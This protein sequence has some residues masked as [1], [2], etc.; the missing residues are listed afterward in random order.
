MKKFFVLMLLA[1][2][3][4]VGIAGFFVHQYLLRDYMVFVESFDNGLLTVDNRNTEGTDQKFRVKCKYGEYLTVSINPSRSER[5]YFDL[6]RLTVNGENVTDQVSM[7]QYRTKVTKKMTITASFKPGEETAA[8][9]SVAETLNLSAPSLDVTNNTPYLGSLGAYNVKDPSIIFDEASG[10]YY[11]FC[12]D[13]VVIHSKD[14]INWTAKTNYFKTVTTDDSTLAIDF[15]QFD[16]VKAWAAEHGYEKDKRYSSATNNRTVLAP[17]IVRVG[18][19]YYLYFSISKAEEANEAAIFCVKTKDLEAAVNNKKWTEVGIVFS[20]CGY[21]AGTAPAAG[22]KKASA[23]HYD[24][25]YA[26]HPSIFRSSDG[27]MYM[28]Y[29]G[30]W[31]RSEIHG[32]IYLLELD[33]KTGLLRE[34]SAINATGDTVSTVHGVTRY[35]TGALIAQPGSIPD[36]ARNEGSLIW[37]A[38]VVRKGDYYYLLTTYGV[39]ELNCSVRVARSDNPAG[40]Y[41]DSLGR[42]ISKFESQSFLGRDQY[43][44]GDILLAGYNFDRSNDGGVSYLNVGKASTASPSVIKTADGQWL[45]ASHSQIYFKVEGDLKTGY[46]NAKNLEESLDAKPAMEIRQLLWNDAGWPLAVPEAY[47]NETVKEKFTAKQMY[48]EWD[49]VVFDRMDGSVVGAPACS[50]SQMVSILS[51]V[52]ITKENIDKNTK[53]DKLYFAKRNSRSFEIRL[54]GELFIIYPVVAWDWELDKATLTFSGQG[55][56]GSTVWGK[57]S[58]SSMTGLYTDTLYYL[59]DQ[60]DPETLRPEYEAKLKKIQN[61]PTQSQINKLCTQLIQALQTAK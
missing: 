33:P 15:D 50:H 21:S 42:N 35:H 10:Y 25:S 18:K 36:R 56:N 13:N 16:C 59:L 24:A 41:L 20:T 38:E 43:H 61:N 17:E 58:F 12:S 44:K 2:L 26:V 1:L 49:V 4:V 45:M 34:N 22:E 47:D 29:G 9:E 14:L 54:N 27:S 3:L 51:N 23:A 7:L 55:E 52:A 40:P 30:T 60:A 5:G 11:A 19:T 46:D 39:D 53:L 48:G 6:D 37:G 8:R 28:A 32:A 31:G 57:K